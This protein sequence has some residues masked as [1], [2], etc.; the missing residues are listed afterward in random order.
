MSLILFSV[1]VY[2]LTFVIFAI[3]LL[4]KSLIYPQVQLGLFK[5]IE[6]FFSPNMARKAIPF[7]ETAETAGLVFGSLFALGI[8]Q[9]S[10]N[11]FSLF[12][13]NQQSLEILLKHR[14]VVRD[15]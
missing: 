2:D 1:F 8:L 6:S 5:K 10:T 12:L 4:A 7:I 9:I 14:P 11:L 15:L 13:E 3:A